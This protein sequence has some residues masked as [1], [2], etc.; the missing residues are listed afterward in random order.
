MVWNLEGPYP[1]SCSITPKTQEKMEQRKGN[2]LMAATSNMR[3]M[4]IFLKKISRWACHCHPAV[5]SRGGP[6]TGGA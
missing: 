5:W 4:G 2:E 3:L 1:H 6:I